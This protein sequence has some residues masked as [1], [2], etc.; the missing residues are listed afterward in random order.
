MPFERAG[1]GT[2]HHVRRVI[3]GAAVRIERMLEE[4]AHQHARVARKRGLRAVAVMHVEIDDRDALQAVHFQRMT[5]RDRDVVEEAE[6]HR[7][8]RLRVMSGRT[9]AAKRVV[10][11]AF[12]H[13]IGRGDRRARRAQRGLI[14]TADTSPCRDRSRRGLR[15]AAD[16][17]MKSICACVCT[18]T[19]VGFIG[20]R[21]RLRAR[22]ARRCGSRSVD[23]RSPADAPG[24]RDAT[25]PCR[26]EG[27]QGG[28]RSRLP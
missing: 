2:L 1:I 27:S 14:G 24:I 5:R 21:R 18:R 25:A 26:G 17:L 23:L 3:V 6:A 12:D 13:G 11:A 28:N 16:C 8:R 19:S 22:S 15:A 4:A 7:A 20:E 10:V 9:H